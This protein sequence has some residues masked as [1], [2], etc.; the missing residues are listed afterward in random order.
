MVHVSWCFGCEGVKCQQSKRYCTSVIKL[1]FIQKW[2]EMFSFAQQRRK[3]TAT[4]TTSI[5]V[6]SDNIDVVFELCAR[7]IFQSFIVVCFIILCTFKTNK[8]LFNFEVS[9]KNIQIRL[10]IY[11]AATE[12]SPEII[13]IS[14]ACF[15]FLFP[16][17]RSVSFC[18]CVYFTF[19]FVVGNW[20]GTVLVF[21]YIS[22]NSG[23]FG[24]HH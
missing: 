10:R 19:L 3:A 6:P 2:D 16:L 13:R 5:M 8:N 1:V 22:I 7:A 17:F 23:Y 4:A 9:H 21:N 18:Q 14:C 12:C 11:L 24:I 15:F 20:S